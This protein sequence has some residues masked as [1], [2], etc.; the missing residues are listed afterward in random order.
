MPP[1][2]YCIRNQSRSHAV[3]QVDAEVKKT[4]KPINFKIT[5]HSTIIYR[6]RIAN[7]PTYGN[8]HTRAL[9]S[10]QLLHSFV[11]LFLHY[12]LKK[13]LRNTSGAIIV[14]MHFSR[15]EKNPTRFVRA[16]EFEFYFI[17]RSFGN[18]ISID[19]SH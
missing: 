11:M 14:P 1:T 16:R 17:F 6:T 13:T 19:W 7:Q 8:R 10:M 4:L 18:E 9:D 2:L 12:D 3:L 15:C 5:S